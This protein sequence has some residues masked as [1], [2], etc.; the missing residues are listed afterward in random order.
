MALSFYFVKSTSIA[1]NARMDWRQQGV[2]KV[3]DYVIEAE[4]RSIVGKKVKQLRA[5]G[6]VPITVYGPKIEPL[7]L[8]VPYRPLQ[9]TLMKA[10]GTH[11]IDVKVKG[12]THT[13]LAREVQRDKLKGSILHVDFFAV[14]LKAKVT[15]HVPIQLVGESPA[16]VAKLGILLTGV[17]AVSIETLPTDLIDAIEVDLSGLKEVGDAIHVKDLKVS[18]KIT[19]LNDPEDMIA[20]ITQ[21]SAARSE[22]EEAAE[23]AAVSAEV[24]VIT[25]GKEEEEEEF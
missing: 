23:E 24:E 15:T 21:T 16:I 22:E 5:Q 14:D 7:T 9:V 2:Y 8:Q 17:N 4:A 3:V 20:R 12:K 1:L 25:K 13:V 19:I 18:D 10:G 6:I 11:L